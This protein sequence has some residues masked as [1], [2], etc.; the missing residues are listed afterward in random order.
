MP[1]IN[2]FGED[3]RQALLRGSE[4]LARA[5]GSSMG[6]MGRNTVIDYTPGYPSTPKSTRDGVTIARNF[7]LP[8][9]EDA[10]SRLIRAAAEKSVQEA[11]DGTTAAVV[12]ANALYKAGLDELAKGRSVRSVTYEIRE[13]T[14]FVIKEIDKRKQKVHGDMMK[15]VAT[16]SVNND[17][18]L[19]GLIVEA[20]RQAGASGVVAV[21]D[22]PSA[23]TTIERQEGMQFQQGY[24]T[25]LFVNNDQKQIVEFINPVIVL[26]DRPLTSVQGMQAMLEGIAKSSNPL[27]ILADDVTGEALGTFVANKMRG[28]L[29]VCCVKT[30]ANLGH[31]KDLLLDI[32]ALTGGTAILQELGLDV[33]SITPKMLGKAQKV[34]VTS[35][36]TR[37]IGGFGAKETIEK[38]ITEIKGLLGQNPTP[39]E[40]ERLQERL[41]KLTG[42]VTIL[43]LGAQTGVELGDKKDR[44]EDACFA[45]RCALDDGIVPGGGYTLARIAQTLPDG[46]VKTAVQRPMWQILEN[47]GYDNRT[48]AFSDDGNKM[49]DPNWGFNSLTGEWCDLVQVGVIDPAK[50]V[51]SSLRNAASVA[52]QMLLTELVV[53]V[54]PE[55]K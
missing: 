11:G 34:V 7:Y 1:T 3:A 17:P 4:Q 45:T 50:V 9:A 46:I 52:C 33:S 37:I 23:E 28:T 54:V 26:L 10:G 31:K 32:A 14:A 39:L 51:K 25:P 55:K 27:L 35:N 21:E 15:H 53:Q 41:A 2:L 5:V 36:S 6:P 13:H 16:I 49:A 12:L 42:G 19:G 38:R 18:E 29:Q 48:P 20:M 24:I 43:K 30:P 40:R 47:A 22:S 8:G 44:C